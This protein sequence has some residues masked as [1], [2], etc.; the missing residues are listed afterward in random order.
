MVTSEEF[1]AWKG[2]RD[3]KFVL[4]YLQDFREEL[5]EE[6]ASGHLAKDRADSTAIRY[7]E[8]V[9]MCTAIIEIL[10]LEY[11][12]ITAFYKADSERKNDESDGDNPA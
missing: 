10:G 3:T 5:K 6:L 2:S 8:Y 11:S 7:A 12:T 4:K 1:V 9:G